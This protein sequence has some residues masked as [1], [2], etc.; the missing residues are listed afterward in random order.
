MDIGQSRTGV[1]ANG[2]YSFDFK[3]DSE[4]NLLVTEI[5]IRHMAYTGILANCGF[6]LISDTI[7][8]LRGVYQP[9]SESNYQFDKK[10][11]FLRDVDV[12]PIILDLKDLK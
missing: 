12:E 5:N 11:A 1:V 7:E 8:I 9:Q 4:G 10:Y 3:E 2:V 6:D